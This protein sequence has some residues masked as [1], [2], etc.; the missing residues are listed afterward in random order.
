MDDPVVGSATAPPPLPLL[1][2]LCL[3]ARDGAMREP[4]EQEDGEEKAEENWVVAAPPHQGFLVTMV[5]MTERGRAR[6][7]F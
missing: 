4:E 6:S 3:R 1:F 2:F 7:A 5:T